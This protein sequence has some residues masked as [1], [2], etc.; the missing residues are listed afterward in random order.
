MFFDFRDTKLYGQFQ[1]ALD[2]YQEMN[3]KNGF[4]RI[5]LF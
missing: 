1:L 2:L 5:A 4:E 3:L